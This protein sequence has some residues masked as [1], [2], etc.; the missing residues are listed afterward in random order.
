MPGAVTVATRF[1]LYGDLMALF[2]IAAYALIALRGAKVPLRAIVLTGGLI[3]LALTLFLLLLLIADMAGTGLDG[4]DRESAQIVLDETAA[5]RATLWRAC[6]LGLL[7]LLGLL[8]GAAASWWRASA[9][10]L[11]GI[12]L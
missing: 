5:G 2:G 11:G 7:V 12:A 4:V 8:P 3:G 10:F 6:A 1:A 9:A